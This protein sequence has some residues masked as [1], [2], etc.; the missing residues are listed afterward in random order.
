MKNNVT[1][2]EKYLPTL[3]IVIDRAVTLGPLDQLPEL[4][5]A[6]DGQREGEHQERSSRWEGKVLIDNYILDSR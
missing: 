6:G 5:L 2:V 4:S 3:R 1:F